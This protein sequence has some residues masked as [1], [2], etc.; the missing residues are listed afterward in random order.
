VAPVLDSLTKAEQAQDAGDRDGFDQAV[1]RTK[2]VMQFAPG[3]L[4]WWNGSVG[5]RLKVL[6]PAMIE[7]VHADE[8]G[9]LWV[10]TIWQG[11]ERWVNEALVTKIARG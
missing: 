3:A 8:L 5:H 9:R 11:Q 2:H 7:T 10:F 6:G 4:V 1:A